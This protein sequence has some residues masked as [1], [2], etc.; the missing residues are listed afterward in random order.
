L[1]RAAFPNGWWNRPRT[2]ARRTGAALRLQRLRRRRYD[3]FD[4]TNIELATE[5]GRITMIVAPNGA[6]KSMLRRAFHQAD[7]PRRRLWTKELDDD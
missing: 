1:L 3:C 4:D 5:P 6:G 7:W 2:G